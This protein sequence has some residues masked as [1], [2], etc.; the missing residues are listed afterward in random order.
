MWYVHWERRQHPSIFCQLF[1]SVANSPMFSGR[2]IGSSV[3]LHVVDAG[4][5][6]RP[7]GRE[8][9]SAERRLDQRRNKRAQGGMEKVIQSSEFHARVKRSPRAWEFGEKL[10]FSYENKK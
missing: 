8:F 1:Q 2:G 7:L 5:S 4:A 10:D 3:C 6:L 9:E